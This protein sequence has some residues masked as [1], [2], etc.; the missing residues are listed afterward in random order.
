MD[1]P[2]MALITIAIGAERLTGSVHAAR[3]VGSGVLTSGIFL[4]GRAIFN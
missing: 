1:L 4:V 3:V 2:A